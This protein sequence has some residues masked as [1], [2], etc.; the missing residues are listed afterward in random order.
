[1]STYKKLFNIS[2]SLLLAFNLSGCA[3]IAHG[4]T[5]DISVTSS[6][7][8]ANLFVDGQPAG[9]TPTKVK[10]KRK[11]DHLLTLSKPGYQEDSAVV[12]HVIS[13]A[14]AGNLIAGGLIGWGVDAISGAQFRLVP[15]TIQVSLRPIENGVS[16]TQNP[17][18]TAE[19]TIEQKIARLD[20]LLKEN[21]ISSDEHEAMVKILNQSDA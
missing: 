2:T 6:P 15:E 11:R 14:V 12:T 17:A 5:Q 8:G 16:Q 3:S 7:T 9:Q 13:G 18:S 1:M 19:E 20:N 4:T 21:M 10:L